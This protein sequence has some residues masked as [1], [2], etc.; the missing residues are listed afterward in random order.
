M[1]SLLSKYLPILSSPFFLWCSDGTIPQARGCQPWFLI[2]SLEQEGN[3]CFCFYEHISSLLWTLCMGF[4]TWVQLCHMAPGINC[5][6]VFYTL[7]LPVHLMNLGIIG[8]LVPEEPSRRR[9][10]CNWRLAGMVSFLLNEL[11]EL[12][13]LFIGRGSLPSNF[14]IF[15]PKLFLSACKHLL[16]AVNGLVSCLSGDPFL[17]SSIDPMPSGIT[18]CQTEHMSYSCLHSQ[19]KGL[20]H[21]N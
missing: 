1:F 21:L 12:C 13:H 15:Q 4:I 17:K 11:L 2:T 14:Y 3:F 9:F 16:L 18:Y 7:V 8:H 6:S 19:T 10:H 5:P 20:F